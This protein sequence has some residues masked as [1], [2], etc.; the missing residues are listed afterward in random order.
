MSHYKEK[1]LLM[2]SADASLEHDFYAHFKANSASLERR[3]RRRRRW[4]EEG[5]QEGETQ[6]AAGPNSIP[7]QVIIRTAASS[8][9]YED[10]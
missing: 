4:H 8:S 7:A 1:Y 6:K 10:V 5:F 3:R 9:H 2:V